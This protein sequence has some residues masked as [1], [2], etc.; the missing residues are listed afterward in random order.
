MVIRSVKALRKYQKGVSLVELMIAS[1]M[2][3]IA[4]IAVGG[5][6]LSSQKIAAERSQRLFVLQSMNEA[7]RY[8]KED[9]QRAGFN[10]NN[11]QSFVLSG[12]S[13]IIEATSNS[14]AY[15]YQAQLSGAS[16]LYTQVAFI[17]KDEALRVCERSVSTTQTLI[18]CGTSANPSFSLLDTNRIKVNDFEVVSQALGS[19]VSSALYTITLTASLSDGSYPQ[20]MSTQIKQRNWK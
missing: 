18:P 20:T 11:G 2:G 12:A 1:A 3:I 16:S 9:T 13:S 17:Y 4:L 5:V 8:I 6:F 14:L 19:T 15:G 7:L 10:G